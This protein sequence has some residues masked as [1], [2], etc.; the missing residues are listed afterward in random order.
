VKKSAPELATSDPRIPEFLEII[1]SEVTAAE[2]VLKTRLSPPVEATA[3]AG[4]PASVASALGP[5]EGVTVEVRPGTDVRPRGDGDELSIALLCLIE[6]A[7]DSVATR[8]GRVTVGAV[9]RD[10]RVC[11]EVEDDG[12][13][14]ADG[15]RER[16]L[17][18]FFTTRAGRLGL[19]LNIARR[20]AARC[21]GD[22]AVEPRAEGGVRA[23]LRLPAGA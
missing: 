8:G 17:E 21:A 3:P 5:V 19:G 4:L 12:P 16:A 23:S 6:N 11:L 7:M 18:P 2:G 9:L 1:A 15:A 22:L 14:F 10:D 20:I 13:G